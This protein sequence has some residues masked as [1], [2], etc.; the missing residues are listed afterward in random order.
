MQRFL[1]SSEKVCVYLHRLMLVQEITLTATRDAGGSSSLAIPLL[2]CARNRF[3]FLR[4][5]HLVLS[6]APPWPVAVNHPGILP[7][8][9][10]PGSLQVPSMAY[11]REPR[12]DTRSDRDC[13]GRCRRT[14]PQPRGHGCKWNG[15]RRLSSRGGEEGAYTLAPGTPVREITEGWPFAVASE[16][17]EKSRQCCG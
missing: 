1:G 12:S 4:G 13:R 11:R 3:P 16:P 10:T 7:P 14:F 17:G 6:E 9:F 2:R 5:S 8:W 15:G